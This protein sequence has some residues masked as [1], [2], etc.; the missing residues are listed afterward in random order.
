MDRG[1]QVYTKT[2]FAYGEGGYQLER[3]MTVETIA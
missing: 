3:I 2:K 1:A